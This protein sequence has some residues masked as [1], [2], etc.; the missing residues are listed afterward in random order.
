MSTIRKAGSAAKEAAPPGGASTAREPAP[1]KEM[2]AA[3][4]YYGVTLWLSR[5]LPRL[6][7]V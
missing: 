5:E 3:G 2:V 6:A 1:P 4:R 7:W